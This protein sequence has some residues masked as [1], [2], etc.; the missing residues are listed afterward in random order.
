M[1]VMA[2]QPDAWNT[3]ESDGS[4]CLN[5]EL[6]VVEFLALHEGRDAVEIDLATELVLQPRLETVRRGVA[7]LVI[8]EQHILAP[9]DR[10]VA[11][12]ELLVR[13]VCAEEARALEARAHGIAQAREGQRHVMLLARSCEA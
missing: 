8:E 10:L 9:F 2:T 5:R 7:D 3:T 6:A 1:M 11:A 12:A 13:P 4:P